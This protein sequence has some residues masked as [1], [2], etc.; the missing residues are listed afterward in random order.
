MP[1]YIGAKQLAGI[2]SSR[3]MVTKKEA[4]EII[5]LIF[6]T[7]A[8]G[9]KSGTETWFPLFGKFYGVRRPERM[10]R[11]PR[12]GRMVLGAAKMVPHVRWS[13]K[14]MRAGAG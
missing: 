3:H 6:S 4:R 12:E 13:K 8:E 2:I 7:I 1:Q 11:D 5:D 9:F 14:L 10:V